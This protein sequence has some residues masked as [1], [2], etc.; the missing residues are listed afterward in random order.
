MRKYEESPS[1]IA[2]RA[3]ATRARRRAAGQYA[4]KAQRAALR[5]YISQGIKGLTV[6]ELNL[7]ATNPILLESQRQYYRSLA[8]VH[9][10]GSR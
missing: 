10:E 8:Q 3:A 2:K 5:K 6:E 9:P 1:Q 4:T 7:M